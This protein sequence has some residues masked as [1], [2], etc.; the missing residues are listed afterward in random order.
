MKSYRKYWQ[1]R[2]LTPYLVR[3]ISY[4]FLGSILVSILLN[5]GTRRFIFDPHMMIIIFSA[6][7]SMFL[8]RLV[9]DCSPTFSSNFR[10]YW[11]LIVG[12]VVWLT[13]L[14][15]TL[16]YF[17]FDPWPSGASRR[18]AAPLVVWISVVG[19]LGG[20]N[21]VREEVKD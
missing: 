18:N 16:N 6:I 20:I 17:E 19:C 5:L 8:P 15:F 2:E 3:T 11:A 14:Y 4:I 12:C 9:E 21:S 10:R 1:E 7:F 13:I